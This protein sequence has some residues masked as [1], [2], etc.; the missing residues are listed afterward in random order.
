MDTKADNMVGYKVQWL[1]WIALLWLQFI[2]NSFAVL[3][4]EMW[5]SSSPTR[6]RWRTTTSANVAKWEEQQQLTWNIRSYLVNADTAN[7]LMDKDLVKR[8]DLNEN[9]KSKTM[10]LRTSAKKPWPT[11]RSCRESSL[12]TQALPLTASRQPSSSCASF[13]FSPLQL[14]TSRPWR[15]RKEN[16]PT[17]TGLKIL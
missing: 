13:D 11:T 3:S 14:N 10:S 16:K 9:N 2:L 17:C 6:T 8:N 1:E 5:R 7:G 12:L 15:R 4:F